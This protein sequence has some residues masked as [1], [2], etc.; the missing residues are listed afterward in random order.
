M[1][2]PSHE[3]SHVETTGT[4]KTAGTAGTGETVDRA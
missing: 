1:M 2:P 3:H 4:T